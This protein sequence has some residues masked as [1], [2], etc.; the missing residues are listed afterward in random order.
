VQRD[1][2]A[3]HSGNANGSG[4]KKT[5]NAFAILPTR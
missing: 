4:I 5:R 3:T 2:Q 1:L